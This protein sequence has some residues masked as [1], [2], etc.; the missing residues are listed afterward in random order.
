MAIRTEHATL[1]LKPGTDDDMK[2]M[3][4]P[5][6]LNI[7]FANRSSRFASVRKTRQT[8]GSPSSDAHR[9]KLQIVH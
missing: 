3:D 5:C 7:G 8:H 1:K 9:R 4:E 6:Q 2:P